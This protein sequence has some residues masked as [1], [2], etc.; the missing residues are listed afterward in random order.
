MW[1]RGVFVDRTYVWGWMFVGADLWLSVRFV[2]ISIL[3]FLFSMLCIEEY[4]LSL[5]IFL[6]VVF[7]WVVVCS[8]FAS[9]WSHKHNALCFC[10]VLSATPFLLCMCI[11]FLNPFII[12]W[13]N[14]LLAYTHPCVCIHVWYI[15]MHDFSAGPHVSCGLEALSRACMHACAQYIH[16]PFLLVVI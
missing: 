9:A 3:R 1:L 7:V 6:L 16:T 11:L 15:D 12:N 2:H 5:V 8:L 14:V 13:L 4:H 10:L